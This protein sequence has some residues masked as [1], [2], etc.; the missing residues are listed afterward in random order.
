M[1]KIINVPIVY[2]CD[3]YTLLVG[4]PPFET[5]SIEETYQRIRTGTYYLPGHLSPAARSLIQRFLCVDPQKRPP[6]DRVLNDKFFSGY[7]PKSVFSLGDYS[8]ANHHKGHQTDHANKERT[9]ERIKRKAI[10]GTTSTEKLTVSEQNDLNHKLP[11]SRNS[12]KVITEDDHDAE[13]NKHHNGSGRSGSGEHSSDDNKENNKIQ[14]SPLG[15][16]TPL[17]MSRNDIQV[18]DKD[19]VGTRERKPSDGRSLS[20]AP[21]DVCMSFVDR[22]IADGCETP[23]PIR[24]E[25]MSINKSSTQTH[26]ADVTGTP[27]MSQ[28][29][30]DI[31]AEIARYHSTHKSAFTAVQRN[32]R[33]KTHRRTTSQSIQI[34]KRMEDIIEVSGSYG[35][36]NSF[37]NSVENEYFQSYM[38]KDGALS[39]SAR[40]YDAVWLKADK[41][42]TIEEAT[43]ENA[44]HQDNERGQGRQT[45]SM[46]ALSSLFEEE[47]TENESDESRSSSDDQTNERKNLSN[48]LC[49]P[50]NDLLF[51]V[52][53]DNDVF[54]AANSPKKITSVVAPV[55]VKSST[56]AKFQTFDLQPNT[57]SFKQ[58]TGVNKLGDQKSNIKKQDDLCSLKKQGEEINVK[59][60][61]LYMS[62]KSKDAPLINGLTS[63]E[64][65][66]SCYKGSTENVNPQLVDEELPSHTRKKSS[67]GL[68]KSRSMSLPSQQNSEMK[69]TSDIDS[70]DRSSPQRKLSVTNSDND[71]IITPLP[72]P[73]HSP[74]NI[75]PLPTPLTTPRH[76]PTERRANKQSPNVSNNMTR[77]E[78]AGMQSTYSTLQSVINSITQVSPQLITSSASPMK[79]N[80]TFQQMPSE[81]PHHA[82]SRTSSPS[83]RRRKSA[84]SSQ[85]DGLQ[86][87]SGEK[88]DEHTNNFPSPTIS[89]DKRLGSMV[90]LI[91]TGSQTPGPERRND[92]LPE[93]KQRS[94]T[95][96]PERRS[97]KLTGKVRH[98]SEKDVKDNEHKMNGV[99]PKAGA[100]HPAK[101]Q[102]SLTVNEFAASKE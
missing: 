24:S 15:G 42:N 80:S 47:S 34:N 2:S 77:K 75:T 40:K 64:L 97:D 53:N 91:A 13:G 95:P 102:R 63:P 8:Y 59:K 29:S 49:H 1:S 67:K 7:T 61:E 26:N 33:N 19:D 66:D 45:S 6:L 54:S 46:F 82:L 27:D 14:P 38:S 78:S 39:K 16:N 28:P 17:S 93:T 62:N 72:T 94:F 90:S 79:Q 98:N 35:P 56:T 52:D 50:D 48:K 43:D 69:L 37:Q 36:C 31:K 58:Q 30:I 57:D 55:V 20:V 32:H 21:W 68:R 101:I 70:D 96:G 25:T 51:S 22:S 71:Q 18:L 12:S 85:S 23:Q 100:N 89:D 87:L 9:K 86:K 88:S 92:K 11:P 10:Q 65:L 44:S 4:T 60:D 73:R 41:E 74:K 81:K 83:S 99:D 76:S 84:I 3:R 5:N